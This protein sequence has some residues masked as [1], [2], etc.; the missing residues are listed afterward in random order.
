MKD[1]ILMALCGLVGLAMVVFGLN[2]FLNFMPMPEDMPQA[3]KDAF[4]HLM[5][6]G[7]LMPLVAIVEIIG[8]ALFAIPKTRALGA[9]I[10]LPIVVGI[11]AHHFHMGD[12]FAGP[13][14]VFFLVVVW[15]IMNSRPHYMPMIKD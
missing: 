5:G 11:V 3:A 14:P 15:A 1:K 6:L 2:K 12:L 13:A 10:L 7:W 8:G 9:I 4:G